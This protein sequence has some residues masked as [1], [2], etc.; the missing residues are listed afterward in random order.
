MKPTKVLNVNDRDVARYVSEQMLRAGG[1]E[2]VSVKSGEAALAAASDHDIEAVLLDVHLSGMDGHEVCARLRENP[3]TQ[4]LII[5]MSSATF[6]AVN[7]R[8]RGLDAGADGYLVQPYEA[9]ELH[10]TLRSLL[11]ARAS[12]RRA[13]ALADELRAAMNVRDEFLAM[14]GHELRNPLAAIVTAL[15]VMKLVPDEKAR[16]R[17]FEVLERQSGNLSRIVDDLLDAARLARGKTS[18]QLELLDLRDI[19]TRCCAAL[20]PEAT[21]A[22][23]TLEIERD[24]QAVWV[25]GDAVRLEQVASNLVTNAIK[26][27]PR[28]GRVRLSVKR[29]DDL[30]R[31]EVQDNGIGMSA[32]VRERAFDVFVQAK[33][34]IDRSRGGLGLGLTVVKQLIELHQGSVSAHSEGEGRGSSFV[35]EL[36]LSRPAISPD[37]VSAPTRPRAERLNVVVVEDNADSRELME[38]AL[39]LMG[40]DV[41]SA[42][43]GESGLALILTSRPDVVLMDI[44]LPGLDGYE[45]ARRV[46]QQSGGTPRLVALTGYGQPEDRARVENA[47][48]DAHVVKPITI[49]QLRGVL[50]SPT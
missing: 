18:L 4:S 8:V 32:E 23:H 45:V 29:V 7:N 42:P 30:A 15:Q 39:Q 43:D 35:V 34:S 10:A 40:H 48:F 5:V 16:E 38:A 46:R 44:G 47:G 13:S 49:E 22:G 50:A 24:E 33:P 36:P 6:V 14:L 9:A 28:G 27:T 2:V 25:V 17:Y 37:A 20:G 41:A 3:Q 12:E 31:L 21:K 1:Y 26:Y 19:G 11:R